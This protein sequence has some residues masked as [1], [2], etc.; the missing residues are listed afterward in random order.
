MIL[1]VIGAVVYVALARLSVIVHRPNVLRAVDVVTRGHVPV[2]TPMRALLD[3]GAVLPRTVVAE[4]VER[5]L[6][7]R[8]VTVQG[9]RVIFAELGGRGRAGA[10]ALV[11]SSDETC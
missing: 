5:A 2:T 10:G 7:S 8:L 4:C 6:V 1:G 11:V 9:L 3:A